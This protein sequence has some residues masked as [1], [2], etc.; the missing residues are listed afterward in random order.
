MFATVFKAVLIVVHPFLGAAQD[1]A[2]SFNPRQL[3]KGDALHKNDLLGDLFGVADE[4]LS[5]S[6]RC[7]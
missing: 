3:L 5:G 7:S 1:C 4:A 6:V 2:A